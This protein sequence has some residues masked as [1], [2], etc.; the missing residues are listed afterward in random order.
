MEDSEKKCILFS[1][2]RSQIWFIPFVSDRQ[3]P[4]LKKLTQKK[5]CAK[6]IPDLYQFY[7]SFNTRCIYIY[8]PAAHQPK[9]S[10]GPNT[11]TIYWYESF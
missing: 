1:V 3:S 9:R 8:Q 2:T 5:P 11:K 7:M 6:L 10:L 4:Y